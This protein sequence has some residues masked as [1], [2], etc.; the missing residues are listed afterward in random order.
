MG[1][2]NPVYIND[3]APLEAS[4]FGEDGTSPIT[5][6]S[7][8][9]SITKP[10]GRPLLVTALP[11]DAVTGERVIV[12]E[13]S[14]LSGIPQRHV[15]QFNGVSWV[16]LGAPLANQ[17]LIGNTT[18]YLV[19]TQATYL[20]GVYKARAK[21][22]LS[23]GSQRSQFLEF[24]VVDPLAVSV[25]DFDK[26]ID[27]AWLMFED[28][29]DS[30]LGGPYLRDVTLANFDR[31]KVAALSDFALMSINLKPPPQTFTVDTFPYNTSRAL[32]AKA[33]Q[34]EVFKHLMRSYVEQPNV[35]GAGQISYFDRRDY[36]QRWQTLYQ[37][38]SDEYKH[39]LAL[40]KRGF[41]NFGQGSLLID[42]KSGRRQ[43][44]PQIDRARG[45]Y[46][47]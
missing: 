11:S 13:G 18:S 6:T 36:L 31:R 35:L 39:W 16:D 45:R 3:S 7:A 41:F 30:D 1:D 33:L 37:I 15:A 27:L 21:F 26:T 19:P 44:Y 46:W 24:E 8:L 9:W 40:F 14:T 10:D 23:D 29:F 4:I 43:M 38:E 42:M 47:Y 2:V 5:P 17:T 20:E 22:I 32:F 25:T 12:Q 34:L 28:C